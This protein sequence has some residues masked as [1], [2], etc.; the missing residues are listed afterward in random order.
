MEE[1]LGERSIP[2][3]IEQDCAVVEFFKQVK[4]QDSSRLLLVK[5]A[6]IVP[7]YKKTNKDTSDDLTRWNEGNFKAVKQALDKK[8]KKSLALTILNEIVE[9]STEFLRLGLKK[10]EEIKNL[11]H[12]E[13]GGAVE[14]KPDLSS[15]IK[16]DKLASNVTP[17]KS[18]KNSHLKDFLFLR[19]NEPIPLKKGDRIA[20]RNKFTGNECESIVEE[21]LD[22][23][24]ISLQNGD[25]LSK[26]DLI[27]KLLLRSSLKDEEAAT[28]KP[29]SNSSYV[30]HSFG[31]QEV[32]TFVF[33]EV[34]TTRSKRKFSLSQEQQNT[35]EAVE[36]Q[37][38]AKEAKRKKK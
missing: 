25:V 23:H 2:F 30:K 38:S 21:F 36:P 32:N 35:E 13:D 22:R 8:Y 11:L 29:S 18:G 24:Q 19:S 20:Y 26:T 10:D 14:A 37:I 17:G 27:C 34:G 28:L 12:R 15:P 1:A 3:P 33:D 6:K 5:K 4:Y 31:Y 9:T 7:Y 16:S